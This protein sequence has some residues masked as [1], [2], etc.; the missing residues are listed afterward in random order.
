MAREKEIFRIVILDDRMVMITPT[1]GPGEADEGMKLISPWYQ[2]VIFDSGLTPEE[3]ER[4]LAVLRAN[5]KYYK[6]ST[7]EKIVIREKGIKRSRK[8]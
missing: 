3:R 8:V 2:A 6:P 1:K 7:R 4:S 5:P